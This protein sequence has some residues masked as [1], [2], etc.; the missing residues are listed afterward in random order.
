MLAGQWPTAE[1]IQKNDFFPWKN[2]CKHM[3]FTVRP[4]GWH[5]AVHD[6]ITYTISAVTTCAGGLCPVTI[7]GHCDLSYHNPLHSQG[8]VENERNPTE[9]REVPI[10]SWDGLAAYRERWYQNPLKLEKTTAHVWTLWKCQG[11]WT[12]KVPGAL[13]ICG[14]MGMH[15]K[16]WYHRTQWLDQ[17]RSG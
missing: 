2:T 5:Q 15:V 1:V 8:S 13:N 12:L 9:E 14:A 17:C 10:P 16:L 7:G 4:T 11:H 6:T 3:T